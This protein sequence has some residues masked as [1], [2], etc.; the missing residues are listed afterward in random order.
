VC[1]IGAGNL[2]HA[3]RLS[4]RLAAGQ[5]VAFACLRLS[6][7][8]LFLHILLSRPEELTGWLL[9]LRSVQLIT[10]V[11]CNFVHLISP[12]ILLVKADI[13]HYTPRVTLPTS[14]SVLSP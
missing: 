5:S 14:P 12:L 1:L 2:Q 6:E 3:A 13:C 7:Q 11:A 4:L 9:P 10:H 8:V